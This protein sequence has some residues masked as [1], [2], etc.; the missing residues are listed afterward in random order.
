[1]KGKI[2]VY[3]MMIICKYIETMK[4]LT[5]IEMVNSKYSNLIERY[6]YNPIPLTNKIRKHFQ[7][8]QTYYVYERNFNRILVYTYPNVC[9]KF[10]YYLGTSI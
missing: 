9:I 7:R 5:N 1:M 3:S 2:D 4:D 6:H 10:D 8:V